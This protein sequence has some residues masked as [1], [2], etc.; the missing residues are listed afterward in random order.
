MKWTIEYSRHA[1]RFIQAEGIE[2]EVRSRIEG[3]IRKL[4]GESANIDVKKLKGEWRGYFRIRKGNSG[5][6][7]FLIS[8]A[9]LSTSKGLISGAMRIND[10]FNPC[11]PL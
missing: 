6:Y 4:R 3:F 9:D 5:S 11:P 8:L 1:D 10:E 2:G 7:F